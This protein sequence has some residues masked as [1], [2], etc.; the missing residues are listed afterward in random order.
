MRRSP[1]PLRRIIR[2]RRG[3]IIIWGQKWVFKPV[4]GGWTGELNCPACSGARTFV[5]KQPVKY[6]TLYWLP[7][8]PTSRGD[9]FV[10]CTT[11]GG[12]F[13]RPEELD[14]LG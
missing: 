1:R 7:L 2:D 5:E 14:E 4:P 9:P 8:F 13:N 3:F 6:F 11:C 12:K 10:E